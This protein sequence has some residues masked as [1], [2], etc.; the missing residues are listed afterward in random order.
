M[1]KRKEKLEISFQNSTTFNNIHQTCFGNK[2][3]KKI[4]KI[5]QM[6]KKKF[7]VSVFLFFLHT[8]KQEIDF[9]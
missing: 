7:L 8:E 2:T 6:E 4:K 9:Q 1:I 5:N 3:K